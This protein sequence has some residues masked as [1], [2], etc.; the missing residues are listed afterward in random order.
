MPKRNCTGRA[1]WRLQTGKPPA[2]ISSH[3]RLDCDFG[4]P[5][6]VCWKQ[7]GTEPIYVCESHAQE[8][9]PSR[10]HGPEA[11]ILTAEQERKDAAIQDEERSQIPVQVQTQPKTKVEA[12]AETK[13]RTQTEGEAQTQTQNQK[14]GGAKSNGSATVKTEGEVTEKKV[15]RTAPDAAPKSRVRDLTFGDSAKAM[16]DEAIWNL[17]I[18]DCEAYRTAIQAG[19]S[20][21]EAAQ[22]AGGQLA[23]IHQKIGE[24]TLKLETVLSAA[25]AT[26]SLGA[27]VDK[28]LEKAMLEVISNEA[29]GDSEKDR[30]I[31]QLGAIQEWVKRG[32]Q[33]EITPLQ[34]NQIAMAIGE[35]LNWGGSS[36]VS[37]EF[38]PVYR[39]LYGGL[40]T[41]IRTAVP[42]AQNLHDRL[43][44]LKAAKSDLDRELLTTKELTQTSR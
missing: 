17:A 11:R 12:K 4:T 33:R 8:L 19:K 6:I 36:D 28:P 18:G 25:K 42:E 24:Y 15:R 44:N 23:V 40:K 20:A 22:A 9:G 1:A 3:Y 43:T 13:G 5:V 37:D 14:I 31:Q 35:R 27:A 29:M 10:E 7:G 32:L 38:K 34:A 2:A 21:D 26:V 30:A 39:E 41:A 16:V